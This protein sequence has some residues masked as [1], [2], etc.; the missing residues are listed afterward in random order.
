M[1]RNNI[2]KF[3][4]LFAT[5]TI[6][7]TACKKDDD[8]PGTA[9]KLKYN[10]KITNISTTKV[11]D[12]ATDS[13]LFKA[14]MNDDIIAFASTGFDFQDGATKCDSSIFNYSKGAW[15]YKPAGDSI[16]LAA[17]VPANKYTS[18]KIVTLND[19]VL[20]V[21]YTDSTNP[22]KKFVKTLSFKH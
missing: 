18:W 1:I 7:F 19:S 15:A 2:A 21:R 17:N 4:A 8:T 16:L 6:V 5:A 22:A 3:F 12:P 10:W 9:E 13:T 14:C 11:N 20:K